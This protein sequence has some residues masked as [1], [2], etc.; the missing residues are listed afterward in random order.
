MLV[1]I[2]AIST[3]VRAQD[4]VLP[5]TNLGLANF[6]D[7]FAGKP[8]SFFLQG[9]GQVFQTR[10]FYDQNGN[11]T[12]SD[13][14]VNSELVMNQVIYLSKVKVLGGNLAFTVLVPIVQINASS[15][16]GQS[17]KVNPGVLGDPDA[18]VAVQWSDR[19]LFGKPFQNRLEFDVNVPVGNYDSR[20]NINPS[21]HLW[22]YELYYAFTLLLNKDI[23][24]SSRNQANYNATIIGSQDKPGAFYNGN[25]SVDFAI[26]PSFRLEAVSYFLQQVNQDTHN[27]DSH[28]F[29][30]QFGIVNTKE[31]VLG[32]GPGFAYFT[33]SGVLFEAKVFFESLAENRFA[34]TRPTLRVFV[35]LG[36]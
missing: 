34:G 25:Y 21:A 31:R 20:Y 11:K 33:H 7:G 30:D 36:K 32:Y 27:G 4:P 2:T 18:G 16:S 5:P 15:V 23:S 29:A 1:L 10:A 28:Y 22:N 19:K 9:Y 3:T 24:V 6:Y 26:S 14:K 13:L 35:P 8:G 12:P 17:P